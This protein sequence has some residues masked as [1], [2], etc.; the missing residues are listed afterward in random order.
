MMIEMKIARYLRNKLH[1]FHQWCFGGWHI[2][3][4][5]KNPWMYILNHI[6]S[7][8][9]THLLR[10][11]NGL[12]MVF[13]AGTKDMMIHRE[14][15]GDNDYIHFFNKEWKDFKRYIDLGAQTGVFTMQ[16]AKN[17]PGAKIISVE[18]EDKNFD[19]LAENIHRNNA[20][21]QVT[22]IHAAIWSVTGKTIALR[23]DKN[24]SGGHTVIND[25]PLN[26]TELVKTISLA[27]V[28][29]NEEV[30]LMKI[31]IEG[32]EYEV[33]FSAPENIFKQVLRMVIEVHHVD[34][35]RNVNTL[36]NFLWKKGYYVVHSH[37]IIYARKG[38]G[39]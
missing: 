10:Y 32:S 39:F 3:Q 14:L 29:G 35:E 37:K 27:D 33:L 31:D 25:D 20:H 17:V 8:G 30:D 26:E 9:S 18:A 6:F 11:K 28:V 1:Q 24:N 22:A 36:K 38:R 5:L 13:R 12:E 21:D 23:I 7:K 4:Q 16:V 15:I 19:I 34:D 2:C